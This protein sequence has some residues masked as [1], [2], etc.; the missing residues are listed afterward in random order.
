[1]IS[2]SR[3]FS[4]IIL[5]GRRTLGIYFF[6]EN[7]DFLRKAMMDRAIS[8]QPAMDFVRL[9]IDDVVPAMNKLRGP[10]TIMPEVKLSSATLGIAGTIDLVV[11]DGEGRAHIF[12]YKTKR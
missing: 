2:T 3:S 6:K 11:I 4:G 12:D 9:L 8:S 5:K 1:L 10:I 7:V